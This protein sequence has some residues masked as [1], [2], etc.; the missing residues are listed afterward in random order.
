MSRA[1]TPPRARVGTPT[2]GATAPARPV[3]PPV[4]VGRLMGLA[5][6]AQ[7]LAI[8]KSTLERIIARG[9]LHIVRLGRGRGVRRVTSAE[10]AR[11][12]AGLESS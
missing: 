10:F 5:E 11:F 1:G 3:A 4:D 12:I 2:G 9:E 8:S 6:V 7:R